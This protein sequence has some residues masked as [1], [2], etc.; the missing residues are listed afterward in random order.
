CGMSPESMT[1]L[2]VIKQLGVSVLKWITFVCCSIVVFASTSYASTVTYV[3]PGGSTTTGGAVNASAT[4]TTGAGTL[5]ITLT[6]LLVNP[7]DVA[8]TISDL[9]IMLSNGAKTGTLSSSSGQD[10][11]VNGDGTYALG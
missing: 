7:T 3:T 9:D 8:E 4:F 5:S 11:T 6:D 10:I 1:V 2:T